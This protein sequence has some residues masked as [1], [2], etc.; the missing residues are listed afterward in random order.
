MCSEEILGQV[1]KQ[2]GDIFLKMLD[3][4]LPHVLI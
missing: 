3:R 1:E 2:E 4:W